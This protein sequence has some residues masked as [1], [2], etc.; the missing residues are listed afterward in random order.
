MLFRSGSAADIAAAQ[1]DEARSFFETYYHPGNASL[2]LAGDVDADAALALARRYFEEIPRGPVP[3]AVTVGPTPDLE[4]ET[5]LVLEDRVTLPRIYLAWRSPALFASGDA[6]LDLLA[7]IL[8]NGKT[9]RLYRILVHDRRIA[10]DV[11]AFQ[12][13]RELSGVFQIVATA[14]PGHALDELEQVISDEVRRSSEEDP[15]PDELAR[16]RTQAEAHFVHRLQTVG[17]F[18]GKSDQLNAY[19][20]FLGE[21]GFFGR[22]LARYLYSTADRIRVASAEYLKREGRVTLSVVPRGDT[23]LAVRGSD[24]VSIS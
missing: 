7:E 2:A 1:I 5:R 24:T 16:T 12:S 13:S 9:S 15:T 21:P 20:V 18:G 14:A 10:T 19:N 22:D 11:A 23:A 4:S 17:G 6:E 8:A 3:Q